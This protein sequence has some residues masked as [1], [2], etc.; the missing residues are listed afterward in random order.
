MFSRSTFSLIRTATKSTTT[1][2]AMRNATRGFATVAT[3][4]VRSQQQNLIGVG[5]GCFLGVGLI[6]FVDQKVGISP[7]SPAINPQ[8]EARTLS[9]AATAEKEPPSLMKVSRSAHYI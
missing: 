9:A 8:T 2:A 4:T 1:V 6:K 3:N 5:T 7:N